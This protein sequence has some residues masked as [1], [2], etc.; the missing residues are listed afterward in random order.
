MRVQATGPPAGPRFPNRVLGQ[1]ILPPETVGM[2]VLFGGEP[3]TDLRGLVATQH[4]EATPQQIQQARNRRI[5]RPIV[6]PNVW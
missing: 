6:E 5:G 4:A 1:N 3:P 2:A